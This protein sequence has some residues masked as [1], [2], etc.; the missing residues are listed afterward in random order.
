MTI[1]IA[2][3]VKTIMNSDQ[4]FVMEGGKMIEE[5]RFKDL[6]KFKNTNIEEEQEESPTKMLN[7]AATLDD[8]EVVEVVPEPEKKKDEE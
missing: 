7:K 6:N 3:R 1:T 2:H 4:I 8:P 5:G